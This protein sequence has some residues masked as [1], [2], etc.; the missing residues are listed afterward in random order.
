MADADSDPE[1]QDWRK[2]LDE[3]KA[4]QKMVQK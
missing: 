2:L 1:I 4:L 3:R